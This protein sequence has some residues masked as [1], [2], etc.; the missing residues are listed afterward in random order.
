MIRISAVSHVRPTT[1]RVRESLFNIFSSVVGEKFLDLFAGS[2]LVG[3]EALSRGAD[4][5]VFVEKD[6]GV[7]DALKENI[8]RFGFALKAYTVVAPVQKA[9]EV[10]RRRGDRFDVIFADP[11]YNEG[12]ASETMHCLE[13]GELI[14]PDGVFVL[15]HSAKE[16]IGEL[17]PGTLLLIDQRRYGDTIL[18]FFRKDSSDGAA[19]E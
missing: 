19:D 6:P 5:V 3:L 15:Q 11:P 4:Q 18:S 16:I 9:L 10:F 2:G 14:A 12:L 8:S 17:K 7:A 1:D 13:S